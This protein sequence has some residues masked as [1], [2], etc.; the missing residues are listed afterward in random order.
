M[1]TNLWFSGGAVVTPQ[2]EPLKIVEKGSRLLTWN[3][4]TQRSQRPKHLKLIFFHIIHAIA[5][6]SAKTETWPKPKPKRDAPE[7]GSGSVGSVVFTGSVEVCASDVMPL[8][9]TVDT[10]VVV[11]V[12]P[13]VSV[14]SVVA[15]VPDGSAVVDVCPSEG[16]DSVMSE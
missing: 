13:S 4:N 6:K 5:S 10:D 7:G 3:S 2:T 8:V 1:T 12:V 9:D 16:S 11:P 15:E 14:V